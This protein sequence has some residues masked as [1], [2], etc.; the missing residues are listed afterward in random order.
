MLN[1]E[2]G[3]EI[4]MC[5]SFIIQRSSF[6]VMD[7]G[8][9]PLRDILSR[10]FIARGWGRQQERL[11]LEQA[12]AEAV[13]PQGAKQTRVNA[14]RRGVLEVVVGN[15]I[16]LQELC[17]FQKRRLLDEVRRRLPGVTLTDLRFRAGVVND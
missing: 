13:G 10:L 6:I 8:P 17:H 4:G 2:R 12:W 11:Q 7:K 1:D 3:M 16:L 14:L 5:M 15:S 9:E